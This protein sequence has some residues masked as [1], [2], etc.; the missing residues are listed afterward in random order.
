MTEPEPRKQDNLEDVQV[1]SSSLEDSVSPEISDK[2]IFTYKNKLE[3]LMENDFEEDDEDVNDLTNQIRSL[4]KEQKAYRRK[5]RINKEKAAHYGLLDTPAYIIM[6]IEDDE[7]AVAELGRK[8]ETATQDLQQRRM[9]LKNKPS[10]ASGRKDNTDEMEKWFERL[11]PSEKFFVVTLSMFNSINYPDFKAI[12]QTLLEVINPQAESSQEPK[13]LDSY[14]PMSDEERLKKC[15]AETRFAPNRQEEIIKFK[16]DNYP[17]D[18]H[19]LVRRRYRDLL[20]DL[21]PALDRIVK[22]YS[23]NWNIRVSAAIAVAEIGRLGFQSITHQV[24]NSWASDGRTSVR[25]TAG[26]TL[27]YLAEDETIRKDV[28][29]L[30]E[31]WSR[32]GRPGSGETWMYRW[33]AASTYKQLGLSDQE[34][35]IN[36]SYTGLKQVAAYDDIRVARATIHSL[37]VLSLQG[38]LEPTLL[39]VKRWLE[40]PIPQPRTRSRTEL[41]A[42]PLHLTALLA[43]RELAKVHSA[44]ITAEDDSQ[45]HLISNMLALIE[46][47]RHEAGPIW[48]MNV[49]IGIS[50]F[51]FNAREIFYSLI[52]FWSEQAAGTPLQATLT[53]L[54]AN[55]FV[56]LKAPRDKERLW[57]RLKRWEQQN[58]EDGLPRLAAEARQEIKKRIL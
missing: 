11:P 53:N 40:E 2:A 38:R 55:V 42:S 9:Q 14:F 58:R 22:T 16:D 32:S 10:S 21:L 27:A 28:K 15:R 18:I 52:S 30:L 33:T 1:S 8:I 57:N 46:Q 6:E 17:K 37:I 39:V 13:S 35:A 29:K 45:D 36:W 5:L 12:Q 41:I 26:Y 47:S 19:D 49:D 50:A 20:L 44:D 48:Q 54:I 7:S 51:R 34:W 23:S 25:A 3:D 43:V 31:S 56:G 24:L 4:L